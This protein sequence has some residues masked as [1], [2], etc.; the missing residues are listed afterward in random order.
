MP[1]FLLS[2]NCIDVNVST[3]TLQQRKIFKS[4]HPINQVKYQVGLLS[5][6]F[7]INQ[8]YYALEDHSG[9][10]EQMESVKLFPNPVENTLNIE[11][12][13]NFF[14]QKLKVAVFNIYGR[15]VF[16][17]SYN[18][19][20]FSVPFQRY[21]NGNYYLKIFSDHNNYKQVKFLKIN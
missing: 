5:V 18:G 20:K 8:E 7:N 1:Y 21:P 17:G 19:S 9:F 12:N 15:K 2:Q 4:H 16:S 3:N 13:N 11:L 10:N 14:T 6:N